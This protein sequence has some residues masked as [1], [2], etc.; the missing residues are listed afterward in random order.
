MDFDEEID[1]QMAYN[2][3]SKKF[4]KLTHHHQISLKKLNDVEHEKESLAKKKSA[5][6]IYSKV[7]E[8]DLQNG[9][10]KLIII[11]E[12]PYPNCIIHKRARDLQKEEEPQPQ[13][14]H[15][16]NLAMPEM[17][18]KFKEVLRRGSWVV[19]GED[20]DIFWVVLKSC[21][22]GTVGRRK[23]YLSLTR[24]LLGS[25]EIVWCGSEKSLSPTLTHQRLAIQ[26]ERGTTK[27][28]GQQQK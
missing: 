2:K 11:A 22:V 6:A 15:D 25:A 1:L 24:Y 21:G 28:L 7:F 12:Y 5:E 10:L 17:K 14:Y 19:V 9:K 23:A 27:E 4:V 16:G 3:L 20:K 8:Q 18:T 26:Y 13:K